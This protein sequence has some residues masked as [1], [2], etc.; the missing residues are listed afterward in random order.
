MFSCLHLVNSADQIY[1]QKKDGVV[2]NILHTNFGTVGEKK[3]V[4]IGRVINVI[5]DANKDVGSIFLRITDKKSDSS[6]ILQ[7]PI[8][9][10]KLLVEID[11]NFPTKGAKQRFQDDS[12]CWRSQIK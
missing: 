11:F 5:T 2:C 9:K 3:S 1:T 8:T 7:Q 6:Q 4:A 12:S 10:I